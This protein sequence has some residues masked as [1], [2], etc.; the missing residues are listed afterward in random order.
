MYWKRGIFPTLCTPLVACEVRVIYLTPNTEISR[1]KKS[2]EHI[3][4]LHAYNE[5]KDV[6][7]MLMGKLGK[8]IVNL[9]GAR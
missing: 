4:Q 1:D 5:V 7:Q 9:A 2:Q 3:N 6:A 8:S